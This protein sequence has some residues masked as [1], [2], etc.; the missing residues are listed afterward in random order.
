MKTDFHKMYNRRAVDIFMA[1][2][3]TKEY[4]RDELNSALEKACECEDDFRQGFQRLTNWHFHNTNQDAEDFSPLG[5]PHYRSSVR[6]LRRLVESAQKGD[7]SEPPLIVAGRILHHFQDM[8]C[9]PHAVPVYHSIRDSYEVNM[10]EFYGT[11][12][13][14]LEISARISDEEI[15]ATPACAI[16]SNLSEAESFYHAAARKTLEYL[17]SHVM[18]ASV[19][20]EAHQLDLA[21]FW[22]AP[23]GKDFFG[24]Y[25]RMGNRFGKTELVDEAGTRYKIDEQEYRMVYDDLY[26]K[27]VRDSV[28]ALRFLLT[29]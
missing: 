13:H 16:A 10:L 19:G 8:S 23:V 5:I 26:R 17:N 28:E 20:G 11:E 4:G 27:A 29:H 21:A 22:V 25:G 7:A 15:M 6:R 3:A 2:F 24:K 18:Q 1:N 12:K 14:P 9:P